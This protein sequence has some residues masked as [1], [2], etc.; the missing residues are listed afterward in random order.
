MQSTNLQK[1]KLELI[2]KII[3]T[4]DQGTLDFLKNILNDEPV[5]FKLSEEQQNMVRENTENYLSGKDK[6]KSWEEIKS[7]LISKR[8]G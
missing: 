3:H 2:D 4:E 8:N 6:G 5:D 7:K 1:D